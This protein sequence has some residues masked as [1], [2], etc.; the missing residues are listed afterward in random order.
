MKICK[1]CNSLKELSNFHKDKSSNDGYYRWC[2]NCK[3]IYDKKY[4]KSEKVQ[5]YIKTKAYRDSKKE[6]RLW[7][8]KSDPRLILYTAAKSRAKKYNIPFDITLEDIIIP[9][10][11][12][13]LNIQLLPKNFTS[14]KKSFLPNSPSLDK[15]IPDLGYIKGNVMVISM[16]ANAMKYNASLEELKIFATNILKIY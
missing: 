2:K 13:L 7:K 11:C 14:D 5:A 16:K 4:R 15:I 6:Y 3:Q 12:P 8:E 1:K 10:Y 9:E